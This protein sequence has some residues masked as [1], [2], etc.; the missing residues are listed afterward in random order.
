CEPESV[1]AAGQSDNRSAGAEVRSEKHNVFARML[2]HRRIMNRLHG[3]G[4]LVLGQY[5][6]MRV[7]PDDIPLHAIFLA[8]VRIFSASVSRT[9]AYT[10]SYCRTIVSMEKQ[11]LTRCLHALRS[12]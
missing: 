5:R 12:I 10:R 3:I 9:V 7:S 11:S 2:H 1:A 8:S 4:D 6:I